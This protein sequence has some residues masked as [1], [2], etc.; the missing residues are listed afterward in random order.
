MFLDAD[1][2]I[3][4]IG[5]KLACAKFEKIKK[6]KLVENS[7][8]KQFNVIRYIYLILIYAIFH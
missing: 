7:R 1:I 5:T 6:T 2:V 4:N 3:I 8:L